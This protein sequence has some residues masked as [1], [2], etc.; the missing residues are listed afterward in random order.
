MRKRRCVHIGVRGGGSKGGLMG[1]SYPESG[2][3]IF[4]GNRYYFSGRKQQPKMKKINIF[5]SIFKQKHRILYFPPARWSVGNPVRLLVC[6]SSGKV[7]KPAPLSVTETR[8]FPRGT[9][10]AK[11]A[12]PSRKRRRPRWNQREENGARLF[13]FQPI[14]GFTKGELVRC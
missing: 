1:C 12:K 8:K 4:S 11:Q 10:A 5:F 6:T 7:S 13:T 9:N 14:R 3:A 2:N